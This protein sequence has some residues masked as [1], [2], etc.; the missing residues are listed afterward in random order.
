MDLLTLGMFNVSFFSDT[1]YVAGSKYTKAY[2]LNIAFVFTWIVTL[3]IFFF[4]IFFW[5]DYDD[6]KCVPRIFL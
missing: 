4:A 2:G 3:L 1:N 6:Y 5:S